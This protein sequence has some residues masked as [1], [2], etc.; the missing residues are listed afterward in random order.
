MIGVV[1]DWQLSKKMLAAFGVM[2]L[3]FV[4]LGLGAVSTNWSLTDIARRQVSQGLAGE[5]ALSDVLNEIREQ[6]IIV[7]SYYNAVEAKDERKL[8]ER[9]AKSRA[10]LKAAIDVYAPIGGEE[11]AAETAALRRAV[12]ALARVNDRVFAAH[13]A[14]HT[15]DPVT[16]KLLK[17]DGKAASHEAI[18]AA[19]LLKKMGR[20][21]S[22]AA[23]AGGQAVAQRAL[24]TSAGL[25][26]ASLALLAGIWWLISRTVARPMAE[27]AGATTTLAQGGT[28]SV[29]HRARNDELGAIAQA[30]ESFRIAAERRA[31]ADSRAAA[32]QQAVTASLGDAMSGLSAGDLTTEIRIDFPPAYASLKTSF[33]T[34][35]AELRALIGSVMES[36]GNIRTGSEEIAH[37]S[38]DLAR[39]TEGNAA[40]LEE[41]SA[42]IHQIE[43]RLRA[44]AEAASNTVARADQA[45]V[46]V[47]S[48]R[49]IADDAVVAMGRV[50]ES[51]K[52]IDQVIEGLDKIAFQTRVL[53]MNAAVEAGRAGDAGRGFAVVAD[54]V[55]ALAMRAEEEA[56]RARDQLS[57]TQAEIG[58]A[59]GAVRNVDGAFVGISGDVGEVYELLNGMAKDNQAQSS[60]IVQISA[61]IGGLDQATQQNA[62]MVEQTSAAARNLTHEVEH[63]AGQA[64]KFRVD[65]KPAAGRQPRR[66]VARRVQPTRT[67]SPAAAAPISVQKEPAATA[68]ADASWAAF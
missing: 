8:E 1:N 61:A 11:F 24:V 19:D 31:E 65:E 13:R 37:A 45:I 60:A 4:A 29:P 46:T 64:S 23:N 56:K 63:M 5:I 28:T 68:A 35:L 3:L 12:D 54:L 14:T 43:E 48:G 6:R 10:A 52:N 50:S 57:V 51:A 67:A 2:A 42:A 20:A 25:M 34:A 9:L 58:K 44:T 26:A 41:T 55:S 62:A 30:V 38:E 15:T 66:P 21:R 39:R 59:V 49:S 17:G 18:D 27:L 40:S 7:Y 53:A 16:L 22:D 47:G 33:N 36:A 32:E